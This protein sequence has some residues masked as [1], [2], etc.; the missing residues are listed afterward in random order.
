VD[1][2]D[3][4]DL[5]HEP[6]P[7]IQCYKLDSFLIS[8]IDNVYCLVLSTFPITDLDTSMSSKT[9]SSK[10]KERK[11][12]ISGAFTSTGHLMLTSKWFGR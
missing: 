6:T 3:L 12:Q 11:A 2:E 8:K 4:A 7:G 1:A 10:K 5:A 9:T